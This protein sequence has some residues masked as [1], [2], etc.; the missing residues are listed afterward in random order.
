MIWE[1]DEV[2]KVDLTVLEL[3]W[4]II[5]NV[6]QVPRV[7]DYLYFGFFVAVL[8]TFMPLLFRIYHTKDSLSQNLTGPNLV[9]LENLYLTASTLLG[10]N[11]R[12]VGFRV[13]T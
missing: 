4:T 5:Q 9:S 3:G 13:Y 8:D 1:E 10:T 7:C 6:D 11:G 2:K 12:Y